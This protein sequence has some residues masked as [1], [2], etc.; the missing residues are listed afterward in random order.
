MKM[1][2]TL[3]ASRG[4]ATV[5]EPF[6]R[7]RYCLRGGRCLTYRPRADASESAMCLLNSF[8][9]LSS[10]SQGVRAVLVTSLVNRLMT[11]VCWYPAARD[12][13]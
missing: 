4:K 3:V 13:Q 12:G 6:G 11:L 9:I 7:H 5:V 2:M 10:S 8:R 1:T